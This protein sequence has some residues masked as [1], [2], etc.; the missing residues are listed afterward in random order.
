MILVNLVFI[1]IHIHVH[2]CDEMLKL[3]YMQ[4]SITKVV[5][6]LCYIMYS[7]DCD[8]MLLLSMSVYVHVHVYSTV[9]VTCNM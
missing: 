7:V 6:I 3:F 5:Y 9:C 8:K 2:V 4:S 1:F